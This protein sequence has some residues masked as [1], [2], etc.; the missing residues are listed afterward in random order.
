MYFFINLLRCQRAD[1][2]DNA[3]PVFNA[4]EQ[5]ISHQ[6]FSLTDGRPGCHIAPEE[7][8]R[9]LAYGVTP[10][11]SMRAAFLIWPIC[12]GD[13]DRCEFRKIVRA[14]GCID[15]GRFR[16]NPTCSGET[17][18]C[19]KVVPQKVGNLTRAEARVSSGFGRKSQIARQGRFTALPNQSRKPLQVYME[20]E[21][22]LCGTYVLKTAWL[23]YQRVALLTDGVHGPRFAQ[24]IG[25]FLCQPAGNVGFRCDVRRREG[26]PRQPLR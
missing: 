5:S 20:K 16:R 2:T 21:F 1:W 11:A 24:A 22:G 4:T 19:R 12:F 26:P 13:D 17:D 3:L 25:H 9:W 10:S 14:G 23:V 7:V 15:F 6:R 18:R 8:R